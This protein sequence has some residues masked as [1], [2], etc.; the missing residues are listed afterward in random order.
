MRDGATAPCRVCSL[1]FR[2][3]EPQRVG[4]RLLGLLRPLV[5]GC[6]HYRIGHD[7]GLRQQ[8][9]AARALA[10]KHKQK[11]SGRGRII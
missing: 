8:R 6:G 1:G 10:C 11:P 5:D 4:A 9:F 2:A 3:R 7:A